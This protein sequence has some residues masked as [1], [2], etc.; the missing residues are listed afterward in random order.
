MSINRLFCDGWEFS[1]NPIDTEY[2][3]AAN[4]KPVDIPHDWLIYQTKDLYETSTGWYRRRLEYKRKPGVRVVLRFEGVYMNSR[5]YVNDML[6]CVWKY[7]YST[8]EADITD[9]LMDGNNLIAVRVDYRAPNS[10]WYSG[11]GIYRRVWLKE[12]PD[13]HILSDGIYVSADASG[14]VTVS[15]E[16]ERPANVT[17]DGLKVR[18]TIYDGEK[19]LMSAENFCTAC[20]ISAVPEPV[21]N[22]D[23]ECKYSVNNFNFKVDDA[24]LWDIESPNL[25]NCKVEL[26]REGEVIDS[27]ESK[28]GF[29]KIEFTPDKGF[30][31]NGRHVKI[32]GACQHHDLGSLGA[33][34]NKNA[35][36]RQLAKLKVLGINAIRTTH[37]MPAAEL[38]EL[39]DEM[40]FLV[41]SE[42]FDMWERHKT[43]NDY[44]GFFRDWIDRDISS[45]VRRDRNHPCII[46][47][48]LGNEI[49]DT[50]ADERGQEIVT[51]L[52]NRVRQHDYRNNCYITHGSNYMQWENAQKCTDILKLAGY[53]YA[54]R[55]YDE[56]HR[57]HPDWMIYGSE[58]SSVLQSR[59][60]YHFPL[61]EAILSDDDEQCSALGNTTVPWGAKTT[62]AC[63]IP[64]RDREYCAGQFIWT[65]WDYIGEPTPYATKN[66]Y[67]GQI[68]TAG[69]YKDSAYIFRSAWTDFEKSPFV[70]VYPYW[71]FSE[72]QR[73]DVRVATNAPW[74]KLFRGGE[75][76]AEKRIDHKHGKELTLDTQLDYLRGELVAI[77]YDE[78]GNEKAR[79]FVKSFGDAAMLKLTAGSYN[80]NEGFRANGTDLMF[81][82]ISAYDNNGVFV[83]NANNRVTVEVS[84][85]GRLI[86]LDNG[87]STDYDEHK[88]VSRRLFSGKLLA[89][90]AATDESGEVIVKASSKGLPDAEIRFSAESAEIPEGVS[91]KERNVPRDIDC[92]AGAEDVPVRR[93]DLTADNR[94]FTPDRREIT[95]NV[96]V[97]PENSSYKGEI[98]YRVT[99]VQGIASK[100]GEIVSQSGDKVTL[101][102]K[103]DGE[104]YLRA[105]C[106][107]GTDKYHIISAIRLCGEGLGAAFLNPYEMITGGLFTLKS[108]AVEAGLEKGAAFKGAGAFGFENIDFGELGS[109]TVTVPIWSNNDKPVGIKFY[110]GLP[111]NGGELL[112]EFTYDKTPEWMVYTPET[113]KLNKVLRGVHS[114]VIASE[115]VYD[116]Q[117]FSFEKRPKERAEICAASADSIFG[118]KFSKN[119]DDVTDIGNNVVLAFGEFDFDKLP[120]KK[121]VITGRSRLPINSI[122]VMFG[123]ENGNTET[124]V[125]AEFA[126]ASD[127]TEREFSIDGI[128]GR[129]SV[130]FTFLPGSEFDFKSFRFE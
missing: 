46:G 103:G 12:Y 14:N 116:V 29:R 34:V 127:Y 40:G 48:S 61:T 100:L 19:E 33:A 53:N 84:G 1:K 47:W 72:G 2:K 69:F 21:R 78:S 49:Y 105:L 120:P 75:L 27:D 123:G 31:L 18:C 91:F 111:E 36:R 66:C 114:F 9:F 92:S 60:I 59:G 63:I 3:K 4:W 67:F 122:H 64:D 54:E 101:S 23:R 17:V 85:A 112:G 81:V 32:H 6:A 104:F 77:A 110:D 89:I 82:D 70:H 113:F 124:R 22:K 68:D 125:L 95:V 109:D 41:M 44:A 74:V 24:K 58:T 88:G 62:E 11:A 108:G 57:E 35:I 98:E 52:A 13:C 10:R 71:D 43:D 121:V 7:G 115:D 129:R 37:N 25:Y 80:D 83:A 94:T 86:G 87:D 5:V 50:H 106:K 118:D 99:N 107:N 45:W 20:D 102:C 16:A 126:G 117:G 39:C 76:V 56:H 96:R 119:A 97:F 93:I 51:M 38:M 55:L 8:F 15:A 130:S 30:F 28:F 42:G 90:I 65:G 26:I 73:V 79:D 128:S